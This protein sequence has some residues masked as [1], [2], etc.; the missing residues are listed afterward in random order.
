MT[1]CI[2]ANARIRIGKILHIEFIVSSRVFAL[3]G[4]SGVVLMGVLL[5]SQVLQS[6]TNVT[7]A[8]NLE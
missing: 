2:G 6:W 8:M 3:L 1:Q 4:N 7:R 5:I